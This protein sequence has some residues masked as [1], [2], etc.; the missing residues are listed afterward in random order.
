MGIAL[1]MTQILSVQVKEV[2]K[3]TTTQSFPNQGQGRRKGLQGDH[4]WWKLS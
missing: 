4:R 3:W 2:E 1:V